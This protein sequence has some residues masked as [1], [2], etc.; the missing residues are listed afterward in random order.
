MVEIVKRNLW[1]RGF[2]VQE[3]PSEANLGFDLI[4]ENEFKVIVLPYKKNEENQG[5]DQ[6]R[7]V[8]AALVSFDATARPVI[9]YAAP[10]LTTSKPVEVFG[11][12]IKSKKK[13][14]KK[15]EEKNISSETEE[16]NSENA[17]T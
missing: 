17:T 16:F 8:I 11:L 4:V 2:A 10:D 1:S 12:P 15:V 6:G 9:I 3:I 13:N 7:G 14:E 5:H